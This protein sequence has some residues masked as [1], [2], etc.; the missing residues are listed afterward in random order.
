MKTHSL[1]H[2]VVTSALAL[3]L[4]VPQV[5]SPVKANDTVIVNESFDGISNGALPNGWKVVEGDGKVQ[6][7][8]L[9]LNSP[10]TGKPARVV[11][12]LADDNNGNYVF[13]ADMTFVSAV[14]NTRWASIMY[15]VQKENYPYYQFAVRRG[16][17]ALNGLEFAERTEKNAWNVTETNFY[18]EDFQYN[19]SYRLKVIASKNRVQQFVNGELVVDTAGASKWLDGDIGFQA[20]GA[21]VQYDNVKLTSFSGDLPPVPSSGVLL[22]DE[23]PTNMINAPTL[24]EGSAVATYNDQTGSALLK[25]ESRDGTLYGNDKLLKDQLNNLK[26]KKIPVLHIEQTGIEEAVVAALNETSTT[27]VQV[28]SSDTNI[29]RAIKEINPKIRGGHV[30]DKSALNKHDLQ[31][32]V[33]DVH[34]SGSKMVMIPLK[35][36]T[37]D[38]VYYLHNRMVSVWG[39]GGET[40]ADTHELL[41]LGVDGIVT[42]QPAY[43][44]TAFSQY[45]ERTIIQRPIVAAH[46]GVPS[47]APENTMVGYRMAYD[48]GAD[49]IETDVQITKDGHLVIMHDNTVDRTTNGTGAVDQLTLEEVRALDAGIYKGEEFAG[50]KVPTF[51]EFLQEFKGKDVVLLVELKDHGIEQQVIDEIKSEGMMDQVSM[52][53]FYLDS[54][55]LMNEIAP[56]LPIGYLFSA[57]EPKTLDAKLKNAKKMVDYG[58]RNDVTL[59]ASY[60]TVYAEFIKYMRQRGQ[61]SMHWTF[62]AEAPFVDKLK[63]GLIG[64]ITDYT[65]WLTASPIQLETPLK[66]LNLNVGKTHTVNAKAKVSYRVDQRENVETELFVANDNGVVRVNGNTIEA[67]APGKAQVFVKHTFEMLGEEWNLVSEPIEVT[68]K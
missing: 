19:K 52:Q 40:M 15:R 28:V 58:T 59:N 3:S 50:E 23:A 48:L 25:V 5:S 27:D 49:Q 24:I 11:V 65:Q 37:A 14:E 13:E 61:M 36:L 22:P 16:T 12:P 26:T 29:I 34:E 30:Y 32:I 47:L 56:E 20:A 10:A 43:A 21:T 53:S 2:L 67:V 8:K 9:V 33:E 18:R 45:P 55:Q 31:Q 68:V 66:K 54:M 60:G 1:R 62:R 42:N 44:V 51:K 39:V 63:Q 46:R 57:A 17:T 38:N 64:P 35:N 41:H 6:D 4:V 7:G